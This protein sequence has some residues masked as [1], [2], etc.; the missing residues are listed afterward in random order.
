MDKTVDDMKEDTKALHQK[1]KEY[2]ELKAKAKNALLGAH[3][4]GELEKIANEMEAV[5]QEIAEKAARIKETKSKFSKNLI[6][7]KR[8]G[9]LEQVFSTF[10]ETAEMAE[11]LATQ[12]AEEVQL[13][14]EAVGLAN[15]ATR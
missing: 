13:T 6:N 9:E 3:K 7:A 15:A 1:A 8:S 4:T 2:K 10:D 14:P 12:T 11:A 5:Q